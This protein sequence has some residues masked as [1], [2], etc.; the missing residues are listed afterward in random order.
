MEVFYAAV[1]KIY[2]YTCSSFS[3]WICDPANLQKIQDQVSFKEMEEEIS[4]ISIQKGSLNLRLPFLDIT[5]GL[6][7]MENILIFYFLTLS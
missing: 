6:Y 3:V 4:S 1:P 7:I 2:F 5:I